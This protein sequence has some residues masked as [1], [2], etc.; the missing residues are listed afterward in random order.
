[1][2]DDD[3]ERIAG[4]MGQAIEDLFQN[5]NVAYTSSAGNDGSYGFRRAWSSMTA[6]VGGITGTFFNVNLTPLQRFVLPANA[7]MLLAVDWSQ[8]Y[9]E[10]GDPSPQFQ[11]PTN[12][13]V[14]IVRLDTGAI[15]AR[16]NSL[17]QNTDE[18]NQF[19]FFTNTLNT[20]FFALAFQLVSGPAPG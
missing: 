12:I 19:V 16:F 11:V 15:V 4:R 20:N 18:A 10:G 17:N 1:M 13:N 6:T 9:L 2:S 14:Y 8:A 3:E 5:Q 7:S